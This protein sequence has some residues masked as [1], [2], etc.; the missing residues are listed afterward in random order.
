[1]HVVR[2]LAISTLLSSLP[3]YNFSVMQGNCPLIISLKTNSLKIN[4]EAGN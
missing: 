1:M 3:H 2:T 4:L